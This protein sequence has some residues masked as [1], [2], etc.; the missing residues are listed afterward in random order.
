MLSMKMK[1]DLND[2]SVPLEQKKIITKK[3]NPLNVP[4]A[5]ITAYHGLTSEQRADAGSSS[6]LKKA[7]GIMILKSANI[8]IH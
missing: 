2:A 6:F 3:P 5:K 7:S 4:N 1:N 8:L